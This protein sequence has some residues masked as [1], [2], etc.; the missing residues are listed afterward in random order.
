MTWPQSDFSDPELAVTWLTPD[1]TLT[2]LTPDLPDCWLIDLWPHTDLIWY[3]MSDWS[4]PGPA[5]PISWLT[6][7]ARLIADILLGSVQTML[8]TGPSDSK[9][10]WKYKNI[11]KIFNDLIDLFFFF[12]LS[13]FMADP[14]CEADGW[15]PSGFCTN[16]VMDWTIWQQGVL[17]KT[18]FDWLPNNCAIWSRF[19]SA[20]ISWLTLILLCS[21]QTML[22]TGPSD[23]RE[24]RKYKKYQK[25]IYWPIVLTHGLFISFFKLSHLL[26]DSVC[27]ADRWYPHG[28]RADY[29]VNWAIWQ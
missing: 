23:S 22:W 25:I 16:N 2:W 12:K 6:L 15:Y 10:C 27:E 11:K 26:T 7:L 5:S 14:V 8:W 21:V 29:V 3:P 17:E 28:F 19:W 20:P 9:E 1:L 24:C 4:P 13:H 18:K